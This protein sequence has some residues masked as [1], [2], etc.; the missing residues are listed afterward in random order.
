VGFVDAVGASADDGDELDLPVDGTSP[1]LDVVDRTGQGNGNFLTVAGPLTS[2]VTAVL[3]LWA[4]G[5]TN[6]TH[7]R[8]ASPLPTRTTVVASTTR[9][10]R[11]P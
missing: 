5:V 2:A 8:R 9:R 10:R 7:S 1:D 3:A 11:C 6:I 4:S